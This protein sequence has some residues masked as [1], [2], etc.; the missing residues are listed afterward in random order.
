MYSMIG[1]PPILKLWREMQRQRPSAVIIRDPRTAYGLLAILI[2][3]LIGTRVIFYTQTPQ[4]ERTNRWKAWVRKGTLRIVNAAWITPVLGNSNRYK[5]AFVDLHYVPF[6]IEPQTCPRVK[7]WFA[8]D[9]VNILSVGKF[10]RRKNHR[11]FL[12]AV[13]RLAT[14]YPIR[15]T[16]IG[17]SSS[18]PE[19]Q[20][21]FTSVKRY[22]KHIGLDDRVNFKTGLSFSE[23]QKEYALHDLFVLASHDEP[24]AVSLLEA[25]SHSLP[26][27]CSDSNGTQCYVHPDKNGFVFRSNNLDDLESH[28]DRILRC[29][30]RL[31]EMGQHSYK[32]VVLEHAPQRYV[33]ALTVIASGK[34]Q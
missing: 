34:G 24:G 12:D 23:I 8:G 17:E 18:T 14:R 30:E 11:L 31:M 4:C 19:R 32:L 10:E 27:I 28:M 20:Q 26:V 13:S 1:I 9:M 6:V 2:S 29:R 16:I 7:Q 25:M 22:S 33:D 3:K 21:E 15:V 5:P